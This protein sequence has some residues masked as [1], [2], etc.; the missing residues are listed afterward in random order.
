[1]LTHHQPQT[2][3]RPASLAVDCELDVRCHEASSFPVRS[4]GAAR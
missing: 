3:A 1:M 2:E 4:S